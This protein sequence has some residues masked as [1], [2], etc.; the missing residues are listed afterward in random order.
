[1]MLNIA[2]VLVALCFVGSANA[3]VIKDP[4][5]KSL[6]YLSSAVP[7]NRAYLQCKPGEYAVVAEI[8]APKSSYALV[9]NPECGN[10]DA[11]TNAMEAIG[12]A[13]MKY[14]GGN[15]TGAV[16]DVLAV[17][18]VYDAVRNTLGDQKAAEIDR[19]FGGSRGRKAAICHPIS[20]YL[21]PRASITGI[22][23]M[24]LNP[25]NNWLKCDFGDD[26]KCGRAWMSFPDG[27]VITGKKETGQTVTVIFKNW[28]HD[29]ERHA[30]LVVFFKLPPNTDLIELR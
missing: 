17:K 22:A 26:S 3:S 18:E 8:V 5:D 19:L 7:G 15:Y 23:I 4:N 6:D 1:M 9:P 30:R 28:K 24:A 25:D 27:Y 29:W 16:A 11:V 14:K 20:V 21:Q 10:R 13:A 2:T 12:N